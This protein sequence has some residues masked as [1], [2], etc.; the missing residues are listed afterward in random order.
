MAFEQVNESAEV[1]QHPSQPRGQKF[2][3]DAITLGLKV[4]HQKTIIALSTCFTG[5]G[6][7]GGWLLWN[8]VLPSPTMPQL[9][10]LGEYAVFFLALEF[11]RRR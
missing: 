2:A 7:L 6:L 5:A 9:V 4:L 8:S 1:V 11:V 3:I 10:G